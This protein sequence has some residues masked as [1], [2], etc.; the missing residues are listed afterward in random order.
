MSGKKTNLYLVSG[1]DDAAVKAKA[2]ELVAG[3]CGDAYQENPSLEI[4]ECDGEK[5]TPADAIGTFLLS[6]KTPGFFSSEK[7]IWLRSFDFKLLAEAP[8]D[9]SLAKLAARLEDAVKAGFDSDITVVVS[10]PGIDRRSTLYKNCQKNGEVF[11]YE[12]AD[13]SKKEW[14]EVVRGNIFDFCSGRGIE[15]DPRSVEF[16]CEA[17]GADSG[18]MANELEKLAM[19]VHPKTK[20]TLQDCRTVCS[21]TPE[22]VAWALANAVSARNLPES[23]EAINTLVGMKSK[24][25]SLLYSLINTF[26][27]MID[28]GAAARKLGARQGISYQGFKGLLEK[29]APDAREQLA[30]SKIFELNPYRAYMIFND[31]CRFS[32]DELAMAVCEI[33]RSNRTLVSG[34]ADDPR[35]E[36][37]LLAARICSTDPG[38]R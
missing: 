27:A 32:P 7:F 25:I 34:G 4:I 31:S 29:A 6:A 21:R 13:I 11:F 8:D 9:T 16:L 10:G 3:F 18:R 26:Q 20:I 17:V 15:I 19:F 36:L 14:E 23:L 37:E 2:R 30:G 38:G 5:M 35:L 22:A 28:V 33:A 1:G 24:E 12:K